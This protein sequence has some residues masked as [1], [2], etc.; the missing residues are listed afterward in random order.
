LSYLSRWIESKPPYPHLSIDDNIKLLAR[1]DVNNWLLAMAADGANSSTTLHLREACIKQFLNWLSTKEGGSIRASENSPWGRDDNL[2]QLVSTPS[3]SSPKFIPAEA[4]IA[5]LNGMHNECERCMFHAQYDMGLRISELVELRASDIPHS[6]QYDQAYEFIPICVNGAKGRGGRRR[7]RI[8]L[9]SRAVLKRINRYHST[10]EYKLAPDWSINDPDKPAF[11]TVNRRQWSVRN[12]SKQFKN[13]VRRTDSVD[14][15]KTHWL[16]HGAAFSVLRSDMGKNYQDR[17]LMIQQMLGHR[18]LTTTEIYTQISPA[19]LTALTKKGK[20]LN[21][22]EE[23]EH[24]RE[25]TYLGPLQ[26]KERRGHRE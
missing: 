23:A 9:I 13:A 11:L 20:E 17:M 15:M 24:I 12:A 16:R 8:T 18:R 25:A 5:V 26:H 6:Q 7:E 3:A 2:R 19:M 21:R 1:S 14:A 10:P 4:A 22:L